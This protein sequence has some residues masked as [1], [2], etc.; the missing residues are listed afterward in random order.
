MFSN[1]DL[2]KENYRPVSVLLNVSKVSE[3]IIYSQID[4][5]MRDKLSNL[6]TGFRKN[7][8][9]QHC[10]MYMLQNWKNMLDKGGCLCT[11]FMDLSKA[12][13]TIHHDLMI[14]KLGAYGFSQDVL[15]YMRSYLTNR[16]QRVPV[17]NYFSTWE[18]II[19]GVPQCSI[20]EPLLFNIYINNLSL[21][22]SNSYLSNHADDNTLYAFG[23]N[24]EETKNTLRFDFNLVSKWFEENYMVLNADK[25]HFMCLGKDTGNETFIFNNFIFN[26]SN[27]DQSFIFNNFIFNNSN[28]EKI[29]RITTDNKLTFKDHI[30]IL[31]RKAKQK[32]GALSR[33][34]NHLS[35]SQK[36]LT[37][38]SLIKSQFNY[39]PLIS[40]F[41]SRTS[42][43]MI[44][45]IHERALRSILNNQVTLIHCCKTIMILEITIETHK[46]S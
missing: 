36:R 42:N 6:L 3:R 32:M 28:E 40:I 35:D 44:N 23:Y 39:Y 25:C 30:K 33:L 8:E 43:N 4:A 9:T 41:C 13:D 20:L 26:N 12:F 10:L 27:E 1:D 24:L 37:F 18:N 38:N 14:A 19:A 11:M 2:D 34:L 7:H 45:K 21:F 15:Q 22:V 5:F 17:N 31:C 46:P 29:P 16:Q